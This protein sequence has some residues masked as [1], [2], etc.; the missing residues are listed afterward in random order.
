MDGSVGEVIVKVEEVDMCPISSHSSEE[1][2]FE[3]ESTPVSELI[4]EQEAVITEKATDIPF[5]TYQE[6]EEHPE[7]GN[8]YE[9]LDQNGNMGLQTENENKSSELDSSRAPVKELETLATSEAESYHKRRRD[10]NDDE[11]VHAS[12]DVDND[13]GNELKDYEMA[14][15]QEGN[16][17]LLSEVI[18]RE[19]DDSGRN[20]VEKVEEMHV[21]PQ[22]PLPNEQPFQAETTGTQESKSIGEQEVI[23]TA[24]KREASQPPKFDET[25][26]PPPNSTGGGVEE[27][28]GIATKKMKLYVPVDET[29][30][31]G[32][33][34]SF[35]AI[36]HLSLPFHPHAVVPK[37]YY[38]KRHRK[39]RKYRTLD[40]EQQVILV[41]EVVSVEKAQVGDSQQPETVST[42]GLF[43]DE[44]NE[45]ISTE[46]AEVREGNADG[47]KPINESDLKG[48]PKL[49]ETQE[50]YQISKETL[51]VDEDANYH[52]KSDQIQDNGL[53]SN[54]EN[55]TSECDVSRSPSPIPNSAS[56]RTS[57][58][59]FPVE[60]LEAF[61][62]V[63]DEPETLAH[64]LR[65]KRY[66]CEFEGCGKSYFSNADFYTHRLR[67]KRDQPFYC[68][69]SN[70]T[71]KCSLPG[72]LNLHLK[73]EHNATQGQLQTCSYR[74]RVCGIWF[75][76]SISLSTHLS[77]HEEP[78]GSHITMKAREITIPTVED[79]NYSQVEAQAERVIDKDITSV[80]P[81]LEPES[82]TTI[83]AS[84]S[85]EKPTTLL[86]AP[87]YQI[88][89]WGLQTAHFSIP[90]F[91]S[92]VQNLEAV[93]VQ[94]A[95]LADEE[96]S[97]KR[98]TC[99][100]EGCTKSYAQEAHLKSHRLHH[101]RKKLYKCWWPE[102]NLK[103]CWPGKL[104]SHLQYHHKTTPEQLK[105][106]SFRCQFCRKRF[107]SSISLSL[108][109]STHD[110]HPGKKASVISP[111]EDA[112]RF[113]TSVLSTPMTG[114]YHRCQQCQ[115]QFL[116]PDLLA[117]HLSTHE[118]PRGSHSNTDR[119]ERSA[120]AVEDETT[121]QQ[122][123]EHQLLIESST[124]GNEIAADSELSNEI[125]NVSAASASSNKEPMPGSSTSG[126]K[127]L[128]NCHHCQS[129]FESQQLL[130]LH[131]GFAHQIFTQIECPQCGRRLIDINAFRVHMNQVHGKPS[132]LPGRYQCEICEERFGNLAVFGR[133]ARTHVNYLPNLVKR[134]QDF[135]TNDQFQVQGE[136]QNK[137]L[138]IILRKRQKVQN[139]PCGIGAQNSALSP[140]L[141][142]KEIKSV[143]SS[144]FPYGF[145]IRQASLS[146]DSD[147]QT[148][149]PVKPYQ[150]WLP[151]CSSQFSDAASVMVHAR[152]NHKVSS[153]QCLVT[154]SVCG[155]TFHNPILLSMH[156]TR[157]RKASE[158]PPKPNANEVVQ[159]HSHK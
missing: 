107:A 112:L 133:H 97:V 88:G 59:D 119:N 117:F 45:Q 42:A 28:C 124:I 46:V 2:R 5:S 8:H 94:V 29:Q 95:T 116:S 130:S 147:L 115:L 118:K 134:R 77:S 142:K 15:P 106:A 122:R 51:Q 68:W 35:L 48:S 60:K 105:G 79:H 25:Q 139:V 157:H 136:A 128:L 63:A 153:K 50:P 137:S 21:C 129:T 17:Q 1:F 152:S 156:L 43:D 12:H 159:N 69:W 90:S 108:H 73:R 72:K 38:Q 65:E 113:I 125:G 131:L 76:N 54:Y 19:E 10:S 144:R 93:T 30:A 53:Q 121:L 86:S 3:V 22:S 64:H 84:T 110:D 102:C 126:E 145:R 91:S 104:T 123:Q 61:S 7:F 40:A 74:C 36:L 49:E 141:P 58:Q 99:D 155:E 67:H 149:Q 120:T 44:M 143:E 82:N 127:K 70:C 83:F 13:D 140:P 11:Q 89:D 103:F 81:A 56:A 75:G 39:R 98:Y 37:Y 87:I 80:A 150:C 20:A 41:E 9:K 26:E 23:E 71:F 32:G 85:L 6:D 135:E 4:G 138:P 151:G 16:D 146:S 47:T 52:E 31:R 96:I 55:E 24:A 111:A 14:K 34:M 100:F 101:T 57:E 132:G 92:S 109:L 158:H 18:D 114:S 66:K 33:L 148:H 154:C 78:T 27:E 62:N